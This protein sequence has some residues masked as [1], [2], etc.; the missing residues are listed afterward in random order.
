MKIKA[1]FL[2][3]EKLEI[4]CLSLIYYII[5]I[6]LK[7]PLL[8]HPL[9]PHS[10]YIFIK[11]G[12]SYKIQIGMSNHQRCQYVAEPRF[13]E[14]IEVIYFSKTNYKILMPAFHQTENCDIESKTMI[15]TRF[16]PVAIA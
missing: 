7:R 11:F 10:Q 15:T 16:F 12:N 2:I 13:L 8:P 6:L 3:P 9:I 5:I 1:I 14:Y 4:K